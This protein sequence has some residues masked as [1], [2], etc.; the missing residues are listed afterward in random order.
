MSNNQDE[1]MDIKANEDDTP[2]PKRNITVVD[3]MVLVPTIDQEAC[4]E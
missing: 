2:H 4:N 1:E 3:G